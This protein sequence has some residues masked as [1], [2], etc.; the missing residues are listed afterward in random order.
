MNDKL[1]TVQ[2]IALV[3]VRVFI[4][5]HF[6]YEGVAKLL[7]ANWSAAGYLMQARGFLTPFFKW[8]AGALAG[9]FGGAFVAPGPPLILYAYNCK[10]PI[11]QAMANLQ[12]IFVVQSIA[13]IISF[14]FAG[15]FNGPIALT[16]ICLGPPVVFFSIVG[17]KISRKLELP[18][19]RRVINAVLLL[20]GIAL[21]VNT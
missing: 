2:K 21:I 8:I 15:F 12:F 11:R 9:M 16:G 1:T 6:L 18:H 13:I 17:S 14:A 10:W 4:G 20:L 7:K 19:L 5:W 3:I